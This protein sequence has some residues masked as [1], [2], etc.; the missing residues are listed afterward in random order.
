[1]YRLSLLTALLLPL[2]ACSGDEKSDDTGSADDSGNP[3]GCTVTIKSTIPSADSVTAYYRG[4]VEFE[5]SA[6]D[7]TAQIVTD[8]P[9]SQTL[10]SDGLRVIWTIS[11]PLDPQ[12]GYSATLNYCG[13]SATI[14]FTTSELGNPVGDPGGL[15]GSTFLVDLGSARIVE[16][17]GIGKVLSAYLTTDILIGVSSVTDTEIKMMGALA[18]EGS[19]PAMQDYCDPSIDFPTADFIDSCYFSVGPEDTIFA[20]SGYEIVVESLVLN[21]TIAPD[22]SYFDGGVLSGTI[23][24][25]PLA[26]LLGDPKD[27]GAIC[28][29]AINFGAACEACPSDGEQFCLS[30]VADQ[31]YAEAVSGLSLVAVAGDDC[32]G[33]ES[34]PPDPETCTE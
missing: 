29:L 10:S 8:I 7:G 13:G 3:D 6:P 30:L 16:P 22:G 20:V 15:V 23:D 14:N 5:L 9:G 34:G 2:G 1:M 19:S 18:V 31:I 33:C 26:A 28:E 12:A 27:V 25:R 32:A 4:N 21:G 11:S 24:T 17:P